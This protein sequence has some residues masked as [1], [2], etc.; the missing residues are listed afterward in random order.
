MVTV[1]DDFAERLQEAMDSRGISQY[2]LAKL[3]DIA[4]STLSMY[5][6]RKRTPAGDV[7]QRISPIL[8]V[9]TDFLLGLVDSPLSNL[10]GEV[11]N[12]NLKSQKQIPILG[13]VSAGSGVP[14]EDDV[15]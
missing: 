11:T 2:E 3:A 15:I 14:A 5:L 7:L 4:Q 9:S 6:S 13:Q 1:L 12:A 8:G 10:R